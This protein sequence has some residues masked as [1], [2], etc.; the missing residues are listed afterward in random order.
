MTR[1]MDPPPSPPPW[2]EAEAP[3]GVPEAVVVGR[4]DQ[5]G[6]RRKALGQEGPRGPVGP[7]G[8]DKCKEP[9]TM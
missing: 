7:G 8:P 5:R 2:P 3:E 6:I 1:R 4:P 9:N